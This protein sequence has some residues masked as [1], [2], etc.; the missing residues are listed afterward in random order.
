MAGVISHQDPTRVNVGSTA[1]AVAYARAVETEKGVLALAVDPYAKHL[2]LSIGKECMETIL[3]QMDPNKPSQEVVDKEMGKRAVTMA[4]RTRKID[5]ILLSNIEKKGITQIITLGAGLDTRPWRLGQFFPNDAENGS[6]IPSR[7]SVEI[8][9]LKKT[10]K[11]DVNWFELDFAEMFQFKLGV[12]DSHGATLS[13]KYHPVIAD[14]SLPGWIDKLVAV[15]YNPQIPSVWLLEGFINYLTEEEATSLFTT[16]KLESV[17][18]DDSCILMTSVSQSRTAQW[19][20]HS[21][22][23]ED[24]YRFVA[25]LGYHGIQEEFALIAKNEYNRSTSD[26]S[27]NYYLLQLYKNL[28]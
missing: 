6:G 21:F 14:L 8:E 24:P 15:G 2:A 27:S 19:H 28:S 13:V 3:T 11:E 17:T 26:F 7:T 10:L 16:L 18:A 23:P 12:L 20:M 22:R 9:A 4:V 1:H 5:D 25:N